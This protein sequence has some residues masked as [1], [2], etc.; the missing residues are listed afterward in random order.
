MQAT[1]TQTQALLF[2]F[3]VLALILETWAATGHP[4]CG[5][6]DVEIQERCHRHLKEVKVQYI[7]TE[8]LADV[9]V[10]WGEEM[11]SVGRKGNQGHEEVLDV[12]L[13]QS[14]RPQAVL[15]YPAEVR[16]Q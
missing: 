11:G 1:Q 16:K 2:L 4:I 14:V 12:L 8:D 10:Y 9:D 15:D 3:H 6:G 13:L 7:Y 5:A